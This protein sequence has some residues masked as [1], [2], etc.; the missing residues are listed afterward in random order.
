MK[1][2]KITYG[3]YGMM[4]Y[5]TVVKLG[6]KIP[7]KIAFSDGSMTAIGTSPATY[8]TDDIVVQ[9][10]IENSEDYTRGLVKL[11]KE[12][13][14]EDE[15]PIER[16]PEPEP[17]PEAESE[18]KEEVVEQSEPA[19]EKKVF[20]CRDDARDYLETT[21]GV[22]RTKLHKTESIIAAGKENGIEIVIE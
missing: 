5:H 9:H 21:F 10:A 2:K 1:K 14:L 3:V 18:E 6:G 22:A 8:T 17:E 19:L 7:K 15:L 11:V 13:N 20:A 16:N 4:E 12:I